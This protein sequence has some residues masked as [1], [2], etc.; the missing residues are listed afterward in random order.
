MFDREQA[1]EKFDDFLMIFDE[2]TDALEKDAAARGIDL[3]FSVESLAKLE[4]LFLL[5]A[6]GADK[7]AISQLIVYFARY[8]GE[9]V[10]INYGGKWI[11]SLDD[12]KNV[13]FNTPVIVGHTPI[14]DLEFDPIGQMRA[15][16]L[17][18]RP[19]MLWQAIDA[20]IN[21]NPLDLSDLVEE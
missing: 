2:Q 21:P 9:I 15:F 7:D 16:S 14:P 17:K 12:P 13:N 18:K 20:D 5:M 8:L 4:Q 1:L 10:R 11:L 6:E 3:D 19:G